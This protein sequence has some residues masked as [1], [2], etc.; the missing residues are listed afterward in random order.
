MSNVGGDVNGL[1]VYFK[2]WTTEDWYSIS[3][4]TLHE[5][6]GGQVGS[7]QIKLILHCLTN[8]ALK[9]VTEL[10]TGTI[11]ILS[12]SGP[13]LSIPIFITEKNYFNNFLTLSFICTKNDNDFFITKTESQS[14]KGIEDAIST[15]FP[16]Y[17]SNIDPTTELTKLRLVQINESGRDFCNKLALGWRPN[18]V[19][20]YTLD[21]NLLIRDITDTEGKLEV[22]MGKTR[23]FTKFPTMSRTPL[24][25]TVPYNPWE[26]ESKD[27]EEN[28]TRKDYSEDAPENITSRVFKNTYCMASSQF[29]RLLEASC[30]NSRL[31]TSKFYSEGEILA[32]TFPFYRIG[33]IVKLI[34]TGYGVTDADI[35]SDMSPRLISKNFLIGSW[36]LFWSGVGAEGLTDSHGY[37]F[38]VT[39]KI[40]GLDRNE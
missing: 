20:G 36:S 13:T 16:N 39:S 3:V 25:D 4:L 7:G 2:P 32:N 37:N 30:F 23:L 17:D 11:E 12:D 6:L 40:Y 21:G 8:E 14:Y 22:A 26:K 10:R 24:L 5:E 15:Y 28:L 38:S 35:E 33:D 9:K 31:Y 29:N 19:F 1:S 27:L 34:N 18:S